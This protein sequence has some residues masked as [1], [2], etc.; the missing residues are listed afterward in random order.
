MSYHNLVTFNAMQYADYN[1]AC[2]HGATYCTPSTVDA[3]SCRSGMYDIEE[4][5]RTLLEAAGCET[6]FLFG[7]VAD[8]GEFV[9][10]NA[11]T[12]MMGEEDFCNAEP[13]EVIDNLANLQKYAGD[14]R[15]LALESMGQSIDAY[16]C[17][18]INTSHL[19]TMAQSDLNGLAH[20][21]EMIFARDTG[22]FVKLYDDVESNNEMFKD[23]AE[24]QYIA[25]LALASEHRMIEFDGDAAYY[26]GLPKFDNEMGE[27]VHF[28]AG[29]HIPEDVQKDLV[30]DQKLSDEDK[31]AILTEAWNAAQTF[32]A[33]SGFRFSVMTKRAFFD[34]Q[35]LGTKEWPVIVLDAGGAKDYV[36]VGPDESRAE[37]MT[38][39]R[40]CF[41]RITR[42]LIPVGQFN[43]DCVIAAI[44]DL[45]GFGK[46]V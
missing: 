42:H 35:P 2:K 39:E 9:T 32:N 19:S 15:A 5:C 38:V 41:G 24:L 16:N 17:I 45:T 3:M 13:D 7:V 44:K 4:V 14:R 34:R 20:T 23:S 25:E 37:R 31:D 27:V 29:Q 1:E 8:N 21:S 28:E 22:W 36:L 10:L 46:D 43:E 33:I 18:G 12:T 11:I 40:N 26:D 6:D 30:S